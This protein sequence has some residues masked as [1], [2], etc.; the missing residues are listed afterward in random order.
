MLDALITFAIRVASAG[1]M[2]GL[3]VMLARAMDLESYGNY[4]TLWTWLITLGS[5]GAL[6]FAESS[7]RFLPR[8]RARGRE[9]HVVGYWRFGLWAV[10]LGSSL[11]ALIAAALAV[12]F[13]SQTTPGVIALYI[14]LG[15]PFLAIEYYLDGVCRS[16]GWN[17]FTSITVFIVR[18]LLIAVLAL[19]CIAAG[20]PITLQVIG[21]IITM[22]LVAIALLMVAVIAWRL[23][24]IVRTPFRLRR[25]T[26]REAMWLKASAPMLLVS[27]LDDILTYSDVLILSAFMSPED[28]GIYFAAARTLALANFVY[29]AMWTVAGRG[30]ALALEDTDKTRL[31]ETVLE[32]TR[33]TF[34]CTVIAL[35]A[36]LGAAPVFL[37]AFG[38]EFLGGVWIMAILSFGLLARALTGQAGE[39]L[40][41]AGKQKQSLALIASV[42]AANIALTV[43]L[44]PLLGVYGAAL[45]NAL[46]LAMRS[47][48]VIYTVRRSLG[49]KVVSVAL[50][51][52]LRNRL[53]PA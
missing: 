40:I 45:G 37:Y 33:V 47:A 48:A 39:A 26:P 23:R 53:K 35:A 11:M 22:T 19:L 1:L 52:Q 27:G 4:V 8:Y 20:I 21:L 49:L 10:V 42:L 24:S 17:R 7:I 18:P 46:A 15:L 44:V 6:G 12:H 14:A 13:G 50:P 9:A 2:F 34:W 31:Q 41:V 38:S 36:T 51:A 32:T 30:F 16:L 43:V 3:Q 28:V 29:F 5:F 25:V